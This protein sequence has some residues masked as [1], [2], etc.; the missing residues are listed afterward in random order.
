MEAVKA[1]LGLTFRKI[2]D[3]QDVK[4]Y[5]GSKVEKR[6]HQILL[7]QKEYIEEIV[8]LLSKDRKIRPRNTPLPKDLIAVIDEAENGKI[9]E[10]I[11]DILGK[12]RYLA[13]RTRPDLI[14][15]ASFI[16]RYAALPK[17]SHVEAIYKTIGYLEK[18]K[19][20]NLHVGSPSGQI[21]LFA[22]SDASFIRADDSKGQLA[23][24]LFLSKDAGSFFSK[25][26]KDKSVSISSY[27]AEIN[28]LVETTKIIIYYR[29]MLKELKFEQIK[30]T[31]VYV[32][33]QKSMIA[34]MDSVRKDIKSAYLINKINFVREQ[35]DE[36][37]I[38][39]EY[40][41]SEENEADLGTKSLNLDAHN[42]L[43][44]K[45]LCG[46]EYNL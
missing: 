7:N 9:M 32:D 43:T 31:T 23:Y 10:P 11:Q 18:T 27:H 15:A 21:E 25:S 29:E 45:A 14:F 2:K 4:K 36:G 37:T 17:E 3:L 1:K 22:M 44:L 24:Y 40:V 26:Q 41:T 30:P 33:N 28:A 8:Q 34:V 5:F 46:V 19:D 38:R 35:I 6:H 16:A 42:R 13:D 12:I 39:L 20:L